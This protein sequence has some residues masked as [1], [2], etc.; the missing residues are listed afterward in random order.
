M[1]VID[2]NNLETDFFEFNKSIKSNNELLKKCLKEENK[3]DDKLHVITVISNICNFKRRWQLMIEFIERMKEFKNIELYVVELIYEDQFF[4]ITEKNNPKHLQ[5]K[6][7][8]VLWHKENMINLGI[9]KLL[10][11]DW[12]SVAWIDGDIEFENINW[13][14]DT[15]KI[16]T[17]FDLVQLFTTCFDLDENNIPM[18]IWQSYGYKYCN[19]ETFKHNKGVNYWHSGY[20]WAC[21][22]SFYDKIGKIY[23]KGI[24]GSGDY[25]LTQAI[26]GNIACADKSLI[27][28]KD[29]ITKYKELL[30]NDDIKIG[31][32]PTNI[33]HYFHGSKVNRKYVERNQILIKHKYNPM[34][35]LDYDNNGIL[36]PSKNMS[37][38]FL[39][40][41]K[42]Y[43]FQRNEDE[44][45]DIIY[46]NIK[47]EVYYFNMNM[48][49]K[50]FF[51]S[52]IYME[53]C[54]K[55]DYDLSILYMDNIITLSLKNGLIKGNLNNEEYDELFSKFIISIQSFEKTE[56]YNDK[57]VI[58]NIELLND[59]N[60][61]KI[62]VIY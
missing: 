36:I 34:I 38:E 30:N 41:I 40:D 18:N 19:G 6:T 12:K 2:V 21:T 39:E 60:L 20:G 56:F 58:F 59:I 48:L 52:M 3:I 15:L 50:Y 7:E 51:E 9:E 33:K 57:N 25:I 32:I 24:V 22:R 45:Y 55:I 8:Y 1:V 27:D 42:D 53:N 17:N 54:K 16:L 14:D 28:F 37:N 31:Y 4:R 43:F 47:S 49:N 11:K 44:Y 62:T 46:K 29:D 26:I 23:D 5:I 61:V 13:V 35:H 10:P